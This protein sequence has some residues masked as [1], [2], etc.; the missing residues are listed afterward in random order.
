MT[1][2]PRSSWHW[3]V[4]PGSVT[5]NDHDGERP[6]PG[7][8]GAEPMDGV[9][10]SARS[11]VVAVPHPVL[12]DDVK[13]LTGVA[14]AAACAKYPYCPV[15]PPAPPPEV[16]TGPTTVMPPGAVDVVDALPQ[17]TLTSTIELGHDAVTLRAGA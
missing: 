5:E 17:P 13:V 4:S 8:D 10:G 1:V 2:P 11:T 16:R 6:L 3:K 7:V 9:A 15:R 12:I 14:P